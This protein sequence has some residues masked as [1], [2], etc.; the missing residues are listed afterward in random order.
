MTD[1]H[2]TRL[3]ILFQEQSDSPNDYDLEAMQLW[4]EGQTVEV[5]TGEDATQTPTFGPFWGLHWIIDSVR[6]LFPV[7][8]RI[9]HRGRDN[10]GSYEIPLE[11][12]VFREVDYDDLEDDPDHSGQK[13]M[14]SGRA[15]PGGSLP[16]GHP[17]VSSASRTFPIWSTARA[18]EKTTRF[19]TSARQTA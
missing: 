10:Q 17:T 16:G 11:G 18:L 4:L 5:E 14:A 9:I 13:L 8:D 6:R 1:G 12:G 7:N 19:T 2:I 15:R 3:N